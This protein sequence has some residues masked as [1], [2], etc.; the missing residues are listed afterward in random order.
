ML[1]EAEILRLPV[2]LTRGRYDEPMP[3][4]GGPGASSGYSSSDPEPECQDP[5]TPGFRTRW[6]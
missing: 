5:G 1:K 4:P 3:R 6:D 2:I